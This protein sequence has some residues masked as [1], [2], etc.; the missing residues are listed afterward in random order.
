MDNYNH[1]IEGYG[2]DIELID[3]N[4]VFYLYNMDL[5]SINNR[6]MKPFIKKNGEFHKNF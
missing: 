5:S 4:R 2:Y 3:I 1:R 6:L